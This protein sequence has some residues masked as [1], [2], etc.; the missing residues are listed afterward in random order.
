MTVTTET[1]QRALSDFLNSLH[2]MEEDVTGVLLFGSLVRDEVSPG[3]SDIMDAFVFL[4]EEVF[5]D[6]ERYLNALRIMAGCCERLGDSG[7][8]FHPFFYWDASEP[9]SA[10]FL[11]PFRS[12]QYSRVIMGS[13]VRPRLRSSAAGR[14]Y[15][16]KAFFAAR[17]KGHALSAYLSKQELTGE[18]RKRIAAALL[19]GRK[20]FPLLAC[21]ALDRW[22]GESEMVRELEETFPDLE[23]A[24]LNRCKILRTEPD[25]IN[26][27][28]LLLELLRGMLVFVESLHERITGRLRDAGET[29]GA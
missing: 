16:G 6:R 21:L 18:D 22:V 10:M 15:A 24:V 26:D 23:T 14:A 1:Y 19:S 2:E 28:G 12:E 3:R 5:R 8:P 7:I 9:L 4:R 27:S 29:A 20:Y 17:R 25:T 11:P 13:D